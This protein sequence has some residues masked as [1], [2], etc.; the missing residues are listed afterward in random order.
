MVGLEY[1]DR[2]RIGLEIRSYVRDSSVTIVDYRSLFLL[3]A[4]G[5]LELYGKLCSIAT[6]ALDGKNIGC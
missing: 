4:S 6:V 1:G 5:N 3:S 2:S